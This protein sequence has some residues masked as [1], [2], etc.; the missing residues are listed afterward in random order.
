MSIRMVP[1]CDVCGVDKKQ[2][3]HWFLASPTAEGITFK[4]WDDQEAGFNDR[5]KHICGVSCAA[6]ILSQTL[7]GWRAT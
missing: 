4:P 7:D 3:N 5:L 6:T 2:V 1:S